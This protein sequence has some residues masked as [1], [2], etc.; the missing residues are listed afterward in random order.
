MIATR[1]KHLDLLKKMMV[2]GNMHSRIAER[3]FYFHRKDIRTLRSKVRYVD[4]DITNFK[5]SKMT[6]NE[7][8]QKLV[9]YE[10]GHTVVKKYLSQCIQ[11]D[12]MHAFV[13]YRS[14]SY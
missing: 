8:V 12:K 2:V 4:E 1:R 6:R 7:L 9:E 13:G 11:W 10:N 14:L 3:L 5:I